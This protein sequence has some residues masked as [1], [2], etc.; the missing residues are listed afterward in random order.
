MGKKSHKQAILP[1]E[2]KPEEEDEFDNEAD[3]ELEAM[4]E[5]EMEGVNDA[6]V[7]AIVNKRDEILTLNLQGPLV[8]NVSNCTAMQLVL[9]E[10]KWTTRHEIV[11]LETA[12]HAASA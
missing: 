2:S 3:L 8:I 9:A 4:N 6:Q 1:G 5:L 11:R 12:A 10:K 7:L